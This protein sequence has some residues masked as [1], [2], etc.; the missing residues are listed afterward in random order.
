MSYVWIAL[1]GLAIGVIAK[2]LT[3]GRDPGGCVVTMIIG[4]IGSVVGG[5]IARALNISTSTD[6]MWF[7]MSVI[8]AVVLLLIYRL[9]I[10]KRSI[11]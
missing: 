9:I 6:T 8:G 7:V 4:L 1:I 11:P 2:F 3:P 10:G 5:V